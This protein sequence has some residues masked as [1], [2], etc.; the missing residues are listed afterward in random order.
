MSKTISLLLLPGGSLAFNCDPANF[1]YPVQLPH[2]PGQV[3]G[4][5]TVENSAEVKEWGAFF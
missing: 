3:N 2:V 4:L 5:T 1:Y